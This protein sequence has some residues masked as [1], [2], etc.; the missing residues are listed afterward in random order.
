MLRKL[1]G[2]V[3]LTL[4]LCGCGT[5]SNMST[6]DRG[7]YGGVRQDFQNISS[8]KGAAWID[9]PFSAVGDTVTLPFTAVKAMKRD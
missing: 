1:L 6:G 3:I 2:G 8:G 5:M 9:V 7:V 4:S